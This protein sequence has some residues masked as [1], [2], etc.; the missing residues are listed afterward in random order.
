MPKIAGCVC[1]RQ[2]GSA[3]RGGEPEARAWRARVR[4]I[5]GLRLDG[6]FP[7]KSELRKENKNKQLFKSGYISSLALLE[8]Q[9]Q[10]I[11]NKQ[12][13]ESHHL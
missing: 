6:A 4:R 5:Q 13:E 3:S 9:S 10:Q 2:R 7:K 8:M 11:D 12:C 1:P